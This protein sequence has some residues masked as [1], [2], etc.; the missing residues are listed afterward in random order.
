MRSKTWLLALG[1]PVVGVAYWCWAHQGSADWR[2]QTSPEQQQ[3]SGAIEQQGGRVCIEELPDG[4]RELTVSFLGQR[5]TDAAL[6]SLQGPAQWPALY[7]HE[8]RVTGPGLENLAHLSQLQ[9]LSLD[10]TGVTDKG[11]EALHHSD[12]FPA[13][14]TLGVRGTSV[15]DAALDEVRK[16]RGRLRGPTTP[17]TWR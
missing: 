9:T 15:T 8:T 5:V 4:R 17:M 2:S 6:A 7:I 3:A 13:L 14:D 12:V 1:F 16:A 11:M 10:G